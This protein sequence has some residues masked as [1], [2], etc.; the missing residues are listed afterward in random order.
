VTIV[1]S[2]G[3]GNPA[4]TGSVVLVSGSYS[5]AA[6][7]LSG[8]SVIINIPAGSLALGSNTLT[9][10]YPGDSN[11]VSAVGTYSTVT[12]T[13]VTTTVSVIPSS[14]S[15]TTLQSLSVKVTVSGTPPPTGTVTLT[16]GSYTSAITTLSNGSAT[17][18][19]PA[20]ALAIGID[21][22]TVIYPGDSNY[23]SA[24]GTATVTVTVPPAGD[25]FISAS[26]GSLSVYTVQ[27]AKYTISIV[28]TNSFN[29]TVY[30][31]CSGM[32]ANTTCNFSPATV[33]G[34]SGS[35]KLTIQ[36]TA[37]SPISSTKS[38]SINYCL[39]A[40]GCVLLLL[41]PRRLRCLTN[42]R[43]ALLLL[44]LLLLGVSLSGCTSQHLLGNGT[45]L[46]TYQITIK[47]TASSSTQNLAHSTTVTMNVQS[48]Y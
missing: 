15:I 40:I 43:N 6:T 28:P 31:S 13:K 14:S 34:G 17:I 45:A 11:Y 29:L 3:S 25:F 21:T 32:P 12:V 24:T 20:G 16:S 44:P 38:P 39:A 8:G 42:L 22:L 5:S 48:L 2:G 33:A 37:P 30:L 47:G 36:T 7:S 18:L 41:L 9:V 1:V 19:I 35:S 26:P 10:S 23:Y 4:P 27:A 46:G